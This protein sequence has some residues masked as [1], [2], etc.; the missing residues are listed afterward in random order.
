MVEEGGWGHH[1]HTPCIIMLH[2]LW[3][4]ATA[5]PGSSLSAH[6][7]Y[8]YPAPRPGPSRPQC[9]VCTLTAPPHRLP[10]YL[11]AVHCL[12]GQHAWPVLATQV[13]SVNHDLC[14]L[15]R[16]S[17]EEILEILVQLRQAEG[18]ATP[19]LTVRA[20]I[21]CRDSAKG[22]ANNGNGFC[23]PLLGGAFE[24]ER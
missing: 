24:G 11:H 22:S 14:C 10:A 6:T 19:A 16:P 8:R 1:A 23:S 4:L 5:A 15:F 13:A 9:T 3:V 21:Y 17:F 12:L 7:S 18:G 2:A 20:P